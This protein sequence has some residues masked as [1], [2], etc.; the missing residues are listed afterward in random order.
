MK[1]LALILFLVAVPGFAASKSVEGMG[2]R[3]ISKYPT[4]SFILEEKGDEM[5]LRMIH[6][7]GVGY[8]PIHEGIVVPNDLGFLAAKAKILTRLGAETEFRFPKAKCKTYGAGLLSCSGGE[9]RNIDGLD[10]EALH[11]ITEKNTKQVFDDKIEY[12]R[13]ELSLNIMGNP[14]VSEL[15]MNYAPEEC[16]F[17][18]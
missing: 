1:A 11:L 18:L 12:V 7:N 16:K 2:F 5:V 17:G 4:T 6:H 13:I 14:P 3:C 8:M 9:R 15:S 10:V